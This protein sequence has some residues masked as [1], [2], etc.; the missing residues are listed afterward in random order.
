MRPPR[1]VTL[2]ELMVVLAV[3]GTMASLGI[4]SMV[5]IVEAEKARNEAVR[6]ATQMRRQRAEA[7]QQQMFTLVSL[8]PA[9]DGT[10]VTYQARRLGSQT[11]NPCEEMV[12]G[13]ADVVHT[14]TFPSLQVKLTT[15]LEGQVSRVCLDPF[16]KPMTAALAPTTAAFDVVAD[17]EPTLNVSVDAVG[18]LASSDQPLAS[19]IAQTSFY[20]L[21]LMLAES[22]PVPP[23]VGDVIEMPVYEV[24]PGEYVDAEGAPVGDGSL[25]GTD[26]P[27]LYDVT[28]CDP[29]VVDPYGPSCPC[30]PI[31]PMCQG[32]VP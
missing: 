2:I 8:A 1:A 19:G 14:S 10:S 23:N 17:G 31:D 27:C 32:A 13:S 28:Y 21:D 20:P 15:G 5:S 4:A 6:F 29:C 22:A 18:A 25:G 11:S 16:G 26:D 9:G 7:M 30:G 24:A 12:G 3:A